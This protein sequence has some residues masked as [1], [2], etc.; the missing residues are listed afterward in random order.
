MPQKTPLL[1][2]PGLLCDEALWRQ[3][4]KSLNDMAESHVADLTR[5]DSIEALAEAVLEK[6]PEEF[7]LAALSMGGYVAFEIMRRAP[8]RVTRLCLMDTSARADTPEQ[9]ERRQLLLAMSRAGQFKG[10]TPR[11]LPM[12]IHPS[13][14]G[15]QELTGIIF[16]MAGRVGREAFQRQQTAIMNRVDS[17]PSLQAIKCPV[18]IICG[19][20]DSLTPPDIMQEIAGG[21]VGARMNV[22]EACGHLSPL[23]KPE[24][25]SALMRKWLA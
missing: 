25:V 11:L 4:I 12:L 22:I 7:A 9:K 16:A 5:H 18:E 19:R 2:L 8:Q 23:E 3:Q 1:F 21:I 14:L 6:A 13:R 10:V 20:E 15:D 17:R 24:A